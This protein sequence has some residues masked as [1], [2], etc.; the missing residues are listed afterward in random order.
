MPCLRYQDPMQPILAPLPGPS[1]TIQRI[2]VLKKSSDRTHTHV[3]VG[4]Q[5]WQSS[6]SNRCS[7]RMYFPSPR[8]EGWGKKSSYATLD[9]RRTV[10]NRTATIPPVCPPLSAACRKVFPKRQRRDLITS[11]ATR[12]P[13]KLQQGYLGREPE[14][15]FA[16]EETPMYTI[17]RR[18]RSPVMMPPS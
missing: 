6:T 3:A 12:L 7:G 18:P 17:L 15:S 5:F 8:G 9:R 2:S 13:S 11:S 16:R 1:L 10:A 14:I 4:L